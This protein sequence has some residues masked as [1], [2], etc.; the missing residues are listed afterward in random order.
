MHVAGVIVGD[1]D[2]VRQEWP[3][4][5]LQVSLFDAVR[6]ERPTCMLQVSLFEIVNLR[7][8]R[9]PP[10]LCR[11]DCLTLCDGATQLHSADII[12]CNCNSPNA[13]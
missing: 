10:A 2:V 8:R 4:C 9:D 12:A 1:C 3:T 11:S 7:G 5:M 13:M 6:Q